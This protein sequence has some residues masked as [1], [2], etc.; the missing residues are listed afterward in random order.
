MCPLCDA[1]A[2]KL[3]RNVGPSYGGEQRRGEWRVEG[4]EWRVESG[5]WR[6]TAWT[7]DASESGGAG[8]NDVERE[9]WRVE[10]GE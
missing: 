4:G 6:V 1:N 9:G 5:G 7:A 8:N 3:H 10:S 2:L